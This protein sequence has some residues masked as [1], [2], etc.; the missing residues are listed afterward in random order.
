[1]TERAIKI[2]EELAAKGKHLDDVS[3]DEFDEIT[4]S[5]GLRRQEPK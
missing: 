1:M 2:N 5:V 4:H 3:H